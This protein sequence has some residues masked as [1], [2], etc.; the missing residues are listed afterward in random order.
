M[1]CVNQNNFFT[2]GASDNFIKTYQGEFV[3]ISGANMNERLNLAD[4]RIPYNQV[5]KSRIILKKG[6]SNY[7]LNFLGLG[8]N[9]TFLLIKPTYD[10]LSK[11][12]ADNF[13]QYSYYSDRGRIHTFSSILLLTGNSEN[14]IEQLLLSNPNPDRQVFLDV[15]CAV[16]DDTYTYFDETNTS[17]NTNPTFTNLMGNYVITWK[18]NEVIA[19]LNEIQAPVL[20]LNIPDINSWERQGKIIIV[21]DSSMGSLYL[22]FVSED[23]AKQGASNIAWIME[24]GG[25]EGVV[26]APDNSSPVVWFTNNIFEYGTNTNATFTE[27]GHIYE[28]TQ[29]SLASYTLIGSDYVI[30]KLDLAKHMIYRFAC[31]AP[32]LNSS[33][34]S[35]GNICDS[36]N[37]NISTPTFYNQGCFRIYDNRDGLLSINETSLIIKKEG[38]EYLDIRTAGLYTLTFKIEDIAGNKINTN[39]QIKINV[40]N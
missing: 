37:P 4:L 1:A 20:Y 18:E 22:D 15:M 3:A 28:A 7:L 25:Q 27:D 39:I 5:L 2:G 19:I 36:C 11:S 9:A 13:I 26:I 21:D 40:V 12:E 10:P 31:G 8:D 35:T 23:E 6:Q 16:I 14:R 24:T 33:N 38:A 32:I 17:I 30:S 29:V 34:V